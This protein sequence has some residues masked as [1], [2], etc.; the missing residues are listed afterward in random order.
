[1]WRPKTWSDLESLKGSAEETTSL[2][3]KRELTKNA[4]I[5]KDLAA[6]TVNGG[7]ILYGVDEDK[8]TRLASEIV[9][10]QLAG[11]E[12]KLR[13]IAGSQIAPTPDFD[14]EVITNPEDDAS[15]VVAV[16]VPASSLA[17]HQTNARYPFRHGTTTD[18]L[19]EP[20][21]ER[22]YHQ[23]RD[24]SGASPEPG[25]LLRDDFVRPLVG[26][27][28]GAG[29]GRLAL[30]VR[31]AATEVR[32][33]AGAWQ[34]RALQTAVHDA[35]QQQNSRFANISLVRTFNAV[36]DGRGGLQWPR[37]GGLKWLHFAS[38]VVCS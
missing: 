13:Q 21:V 17:P 20:A 9:P 5:A 36:S 7:V 29:I 22:L 18:Y 6:M 38:V 30:V 10:I 4:E 16:V 27:E 3:F 8:T 11:V 15:G 14:V 37:R 2:D 28:E 19:S 35:I 25:Q 32:H 31:P 23:R 12:E 26:I 34:Q 24:L 33:P 1:M